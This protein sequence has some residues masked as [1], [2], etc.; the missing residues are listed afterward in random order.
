MASMITVLR[1]GMTPLTLGAAVEVPISNQTAPLRVTAFQE[2]IH[3]ISRDA[4]GNVIY[5][6]FVF[7]LWATL[8]RHLRLAYR[9]MSPEDEGFGFND[10]GT[11]TGMIG[12]LV[13]GRADV[14]LTA[15]RVFHDSFT[16]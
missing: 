2:D 16:S 4:D 15:H 8:A 6:S 1:A 13:Y 11:W 14:A 5:P 10:N 7:E 3:G 9:L 12:E